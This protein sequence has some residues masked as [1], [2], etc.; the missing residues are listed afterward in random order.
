MLLQ[1]Q[2]FYNTFKEAQM[3][4]SN[5]TPGLRVKTT[6]LGDTIGML[7]NEEHLYV[8][9]VDI[10]GTVTG[11]VPGHGGDV[12]W[13]KHDGGKAVGAYT[14]TEIEEHTEK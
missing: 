8:R 4:L 14:Y 2:T 11:Y 12:W 7:I 1:Q 6:K 10:I 5:V 3:D 13:V 9:Q